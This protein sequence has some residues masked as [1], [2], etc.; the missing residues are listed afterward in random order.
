MQWKSLTISSPIHMNDWFV[1]WHVQMFLCSRYLIHSRNFCP[2]AP[3]RIWKWGHRSEAKVGSPI[4][5]IFFS[6]VPLHVLVSAFVM[7]STV[8]SVSCLL[9]FYSRC[10]PCPAICKSG[11]TSPPC[12]M[13]SVPLFFVMWVFFICNTRPSLL[14]VLRFYWHVGLYKRSLYKLLIRV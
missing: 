12:P 6:V 7:V 13:E 10:P 1:M 8:W 2:V 14:Y 4:R 11:G 5:K 9:F 3:E